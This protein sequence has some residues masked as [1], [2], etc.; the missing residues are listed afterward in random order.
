MD[1]ANGAVIET[2]KTCMWRCEM[3]RSECGLGLSVAG[4]GTEIGAARLQVRPRHI[5]AEPA[6]PKARSTIDPGSGMVGTIGTVG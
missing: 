4:G 3:P 2:W 5:E 1:D 6:N